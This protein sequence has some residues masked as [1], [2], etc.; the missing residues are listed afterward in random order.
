ME[1]C[2][3]GPSRTAESSQHEAYDASRL[4]VADSRAIVRVNHDACNLEVDILKLSKDP[5][6][7][8]PR[9]RVLDLLDPS[10]TV[11]MI[12]QMQKLRS[13]TWCEA[14]CKSSAMSCHVWNGPGLPR[15]G[16]QL[17]FKYTFLNLQIS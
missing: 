14:V 4:Q 2:I 8:D 17:M 16:V 9:C 10:G 13:V 15:F 12:I 6:G 5:V 1:T 7:S 3:E 11:Y